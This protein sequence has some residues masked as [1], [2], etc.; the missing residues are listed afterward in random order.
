ML[1]LRAPR[2][3]KD[4]K[5][6]DLKAEKKPKRHLHEQRKDLFQPIQLYREL[7]QWLTDIARDETRVRRKAGLLKGYDQVSVA[8]IV[9]PL[10]R[11]WAWNKL[12]EIN[13]RKMGTPNAPIPDVPPAPEEV[14]V[15]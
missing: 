4:K 3:A 5:P 14:V 8:K 10:L 6:A 12:C 7:A 13:N 11:R 1:L 9:D 15:L 2:V